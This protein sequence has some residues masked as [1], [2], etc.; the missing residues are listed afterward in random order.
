MEHVAIDLGGRESQICIRDATGQ[1]VHEGRYATV[2]LERVLAGRGPSRVVMETCAESYAVAAAAQRAGHEV[3]VVPGTLVRTLGVG[4]R[5]LKTDRRDAQV[6]SEVSSRIDL[7]TVHLRSVRSRERKTLCSMRQALVR[8]RTQMVNTVRG[9]LRLQL[10]RVRSGSVESFTERVREALLGTSEGI[11]AYVERQLAVIETLSEQIRSANE[12]I[13]Q[14]AEQDEV[15]QRLMSVPGIGPVTALRFVATLD[16][17]ERFADA[18]RVG[19]YVGL[20]PSERSSSERQRRGGI[21]K[22]GQGEMRWLLVQAAWSLWRTRPGEPIV[23]WARRV[24]ERRGRPVAIV[25]LARK[26]GGILYVLWRD[27]TT[28]DPLRA[29][30]RAENKTV[31]TPQQP[32][33][34]RRPQRQRPD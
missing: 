8:S 4:A 11:P 26:L 33:P 24:A 27:S 16:T 12:E 14:Q 31:S 19:S 32:A 17:P 1:V 2:D 5:R 7:P 6:L 10:V 21:T 3:R 22:A 9:Y 18:H 13:A 23:Q 25:A 30:R 34:R 29:A 20:V 15:C 28:Y